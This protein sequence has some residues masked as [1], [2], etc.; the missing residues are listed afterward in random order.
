MLLKGSDI[1]RTS[2]RSGIDARL[3]C[4]RVCDR[5]EGEAGVD[6]VKWYTLAVHPNV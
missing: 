1:K 3:S 4:K 2:R 6:M 5:V